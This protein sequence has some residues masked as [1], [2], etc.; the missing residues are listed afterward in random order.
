MS[1]VRPARPDA[2]RA[3][4]LERLE[5]RELLAA[6]VAP[7]VTFAE[8][9]GSGTAPYA[10]TITG[11]SR[12]D[13]I[14]IVDDG[15]QA[16]GSLRV[17]TG[18]GLAYISQHPVGTILISTG[19]GKDTVSY[20]L[21]GGLQPKVQEGLIAASGGTPYG[22]G[23]AIKGGGTLKATVSIAG[24]IPSDSSLLTFAGTDPRAATSMSV[25]DSGTI[26]G[27]LTVGVA[28]FASGAMLTPGKAGPVTFN[29]SSSAE[30]G[31]GGSLTVFGIGG[32]SRNAMDVSY[33]GTNNGRLTTIEQSA[34][35]KDSLAATVGMTAGSTGTVGTTTSPAQVGSTGKGANVRFAVFRGADST[36]KTG[37]NAQVTMS[38]KKSTIA[39]TANVQNLAIGTETVITATVF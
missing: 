28:N 6:R 5:S 13:S 7:Q 29:L 34:G 22:S 18:N 30:I 11:T 12:N 15:K 24:T 9:P 38:A 8:S 31:S 20:Q 32:K 25:I 3:P 35:A 39:H 1:R 36:T 27:D 17:S 33:T 37:I 10:L 21:P 23:K 26:D 19:A 14:T 16:A 4:T 2:R